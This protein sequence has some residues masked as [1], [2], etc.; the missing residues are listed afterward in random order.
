MVSV[1]VGWSRSRWGKGKEGGDISADRQVPSHHR[2]S[3]I[4]I[5]HPHLHDLTSCSG[6]DRRECAHMAI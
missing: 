2:R 1:L 6:Q 3:A 4:D 5:Y